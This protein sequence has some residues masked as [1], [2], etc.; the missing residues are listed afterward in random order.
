M[1]RKLICLLLMIFSVIGFSQTTQRIEA[2]S[3]NEASGARAESNGSLSGGGN[4]GYINNGTWIKFSDFELGEYDS[5]FD[6][7]ASGTA[8]GNIEFRLDAVDGSLIGTAV[9][10]G[11]TD[12]SDYQTVSTNITKTIGVH[13]L[14]LVFTGGSGYLFNVDYFE[15]IT[16]DPNAVIYSL[17]TGV[18][19]ETFGTISSNASGTEFAQGTEITLVAED[20]FGYNFV[21]WVDDNGTQVATNNPITFQINGD[22]TYIAE[23]E[24]VN[25]Y[26]LTVNTEGA[27][28]LGDYQITPA[29][30]D[31]NFSEYEEG[32]EVTITAVE[33][34]II[35]F[36]NWSNGSTAL[37]TSAILNQNTTI[38]GVYANETFIAGWTFKDDRYA[39]PRVAELYASV[40][41]KPEL[42]AY[43]INDN[44]LADNVRTNNRAGKTGFSVWNTNRGDFFY[45]MTHFSTVGYDNIQITAGLLS[46]YYG[47]DEWTFQYSLDGTNFID[48]SSVTTI[49]GSSYTNVGGMLPTEAEGKEK[50]YIRWYPNISGPKHGDAADVTAT[51]LASVSV[52]ADEVHVDDNIAPVL[53]TTLP[54]NN[55][56]SAT[57]SGS[58]ILTFDEKVKQGSGV[59]TLNSKVISPEF[60]NK[61][62][63]F[64]YYGLDY[65]T[66]YTF[67]L[68]AGAITDLSDNHAEAVNITFTTIAKPIP[69]KRNFDLIVDANATETQLNSGRYVK[70]VA[71][72]FEAA[73]A[74]AATRFLVFITNGTYNFGGDGTAP[75]NN[76]LTLTKNNVSLIAQSKGG[77]VFEGNPPLGI[78]NAVLSIKANNMYME[79]IT[80]EHIDG[81]VNSGQKPALNAEGDRNVYNGVRI[82]SKQDT[83]LT[84]GN[85]SFYYQSTI[86]GDV[87]FIFGGGTHWF[88]EC[89]LNVVSPGYIVAPAHENET[90]GYV[91]NNNTITANTAYYLGRP[92]KN[93]PKAVYLNTVM[94]Q[95]PHTEGWTNMGTYPEIFAEY[96]SVDGN[97]V[98]VNTDHRTNVFTVDGVSKTG[99]YNPV[100]SSEEAAEYTIENVLGGTDNWNPLL[101]VEQIK[102]PE[103]LVAGENNTLSWDDNPYAICY[104]V[105]RNGKVVGI[106]TETSFED[107]MASTGTHEY[108]VKSVNEYGGLSAASTVN[109]S[110]VGETVTAMVSYFNAIDGAT[111]TLSP[112]EYIQG[113]ITTL[114]IPTLE[115][116]TFYGWSTSQTEPNTIKEINA[117]VTGDVSFYAFWGVNGNNQ[118][119]T[120]AIDFDYEFTAATNSSWDNPANYN[121]AGQPLAGEKVSCKTEIETTGSDFAADLVFEEGGKL[122]L[123]GAHAATGNLIFQ[124]TNSM[125]YYTSGAGMSLEASL[126]VNGNLK[127][128]MMS[129]IENETMMTVSG[130]ISGNGI[131]TPINN[132]RGEVI[133]KGILL[134]QGDNS[135]FTGTWDLTQLSSQYPDLGYVTHLEAASENALGS[136]TVNIGH[137]NKLVINHQRA[138]GENLTVNT[139]ISSKIILKT[140]LNVQSLTINDVDFEEGTYDKNTHPEL[141]E[142]D[143][144]IQVISE[145]NGGD[146]GVKIPAFPGA[147]GHGKYV[148]GGRGGRVI[149]VTNL[150]DNGTGSLRDA[151]NQSGPRI[152]VFKVSGTIALESELAITSDITIA[153]QTA[154]GGGITL[155][156]Y[157]VKVRGNNVIIRYLR[158]R[159]GDTYDVEDDALGGRFQEN[160]I[161][162]HC[163][164]SWSTDECV[165]FY[166]NKN[167]TLQW[168]IITE[169]LTNSVHAKGAHGYGGIWGGLKASF[170][171]NL[172]SHHSSRTPRFGEYGG[173]T[174]PLEGLIDMRNNVMYNWNGE[175]CY[176]G[177][178]MNVNMVNNYYKPG[179]ATEDKRKERIVST[180][181]NM[182]ETSPMYD[183][184][185]KF[186]IDGNVVVGSERATND[187]WTY[188]VFNQFHSS[189]GDVTDE[190]KSELRM[191]TPHNP[192]EITTHSASKAYELVLDYAG[193]NLY[194]DEVDLRAVNDTRSGGAT[195]MDGGN[196]ST[197]GFIDTPSAGGGWPELPTE[198]APLDTD[199]DGIPDAWEITKGLNPNNAIDGNVKT[200][201]EGYT[202]IEVYLNSIVANTTDDQNGS[203][204]VY[205][206]PDTFEQEYLSAEDGTKFVMADG[207]YNFEKLPISNHSYRFV[208]D[209]DASPVLSGGFYTENA[210]VYRGN[211]TFDGV[212]IEL[213]SETTFME[214]KN[215]SGLSSFEF[216]NATINGVKQSLLSTEG[217]SDFLISK[218][219]LD[220]CIVNGETM[221]GQSFVQPN[222]HKVSSFILRNSTIYGFSN[223]QH[224]VEFQ[225]NNVD[226][227]TLQLKIESNTI[228]NFGSKENDA[229]VLINTPYNE[230]SNYVFK[231]NILYN[232]GSVTNFYLFNHS[233][234]NGLGTA[235]FTNN[236]IIGA[237]LTSVSDGIILEEINTLNLSSLGLENL[238]FPNPNKGDFS[239]NQN[240]VL[241][242]AS[243]T[244]NI[245]GDPRWLKQNAVISAVNYYNSI[246]GAE[247]L[248][249]SL[250]TY[251]E[252]TS[253][254]LPTP[255]LEGYTFFGWSTSKV[256]ANTIQEINANT[257]GGLIFYAYWGENGSNTSDDGIPVNYNVS[258]LNLPNQVMNPNEKTIKVGESYLLKEA[259]SPGYRFHGWFTEANYINEVTMLDENQTQDISLYARW[260][261]L[262][263]FY[264]YPTLASTK[265]TLKS[266]EVED[267]VVVVNVVGNVVKKI[268]TSEEF[269]E[270][271]VSNFSPGC[272]FIK[273]IKTGM[274]TRIIVK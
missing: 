247:I 258:Y 60:I 22:V 134:L 87:D 164:M 82:R 17:T 78:K 118:P 124:N 255:I 38:T 152:V 257:T 226:G 28:G 73:P 94:Q 79:N 99:N 44:S 206:T 15:K 55:S 103:N 35:K 102:A 271:S 89:N 131:I 264:A 100:L 183:I 194:R 172:L 8:G 5:R 11:T 242:S 269:T 2:E 231:D 241:A 88:E 52:K 220:N 204:E 222:G 253:Y 43:N 80:I 174:I 33:N 245:L 57:A 70:T 4:V 239:F 23:F 193:A 49:N 106:T 7:A 210:E 160:I 176:G 110:T 90:Y 149:Y 46:Y 197:N 211:L 25:T 50:V 237:M 218:I 251:M 246:D 268:N 216:K 69:V 221:S 83:Q 108:K 171:H 240:S 41:N 202:N 114:P 156:D 71:E 198:E 54:T 207:I 129:S 145:Y 249:L 181:R 137:Q 154:P 56:T 85:R 182:D 148:T 223:T 267:D 168:C 228:Y 254:A 188:G 213:I 219:V 196:G 163:S 189:Q 77:V 170:H 20:Y 1:K 91:F 192:G 273:S 155:R 30:K 21:R 195:I 96:N 10:T 236:L 138:A 9:V 107:T 132:G 270:I 212:N 232:T 31:G 233:D 177:D 121:P 151:I 32:T 66:Q 67:S 86:E 98:L 119:N 13:D 47:C 229:F 40:E 265:V 178:A 186:Y 12:W 104:L 127:C 244:Q 159:M 224:F 109:M 187:N 130:A 256:S 122:R 3:F 115:G 92:W 260:K 161:I 128:E 112:S 184:W 18:N 173:R 93:G 274:I 142:G 34:D 51:M 230:L 143:G 225:N 167:F 126:V 59:A 81:I 105:S 190:D 123:R 250:A 64:S 75:H 185:G 48:V 238:N 19:N 263:E 27:Y 136:G 201:D 150:N 62:V 26:T 29:G 37:T 97:G 53:Q 199:E 139:A 144:S 234:L 45:F 200:L 101:V 42:F 113:N 214:F 252:G 209:N 61:T 76:L 215:G 147:E 14:Y 135:E 158:F 58:I 227:E 24:E 205:V 111:L 120:N 217:N 63:K 157:P 36:S 262:G 84:G 261:R 191:G 72:A 179:P 248:G 16:N 74:D 180:G 243:S 175:G 68:P 272:Y 39:H 162:D 203:F 6:I 146:D 65:N 125:Y 259:K 141:F 133:N 116:Y 165:S 169:S 95:L 235:R 140:I 117:S 266:S 153:G 166:E 208:A